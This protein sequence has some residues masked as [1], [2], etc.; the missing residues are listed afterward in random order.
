MI[1]V[2]VISNV[3]APGQTTEHEVE[4]LLPWL[5]EQ[6]A[7]HWPENARIYHR[8]GQLEWDITPQTP[9]DVRH[10]A[11]YEGEVVIRHY[12]AGPDI[13]GV[14]LAIWAYGAISD[15]LTPD[16]PNIKPPAVKQRGLSGGSPNNELGRRTNAARPEERIPDI[17]GQVK[18]IPDLLMVPYT[19]YVDHAEVET[20]YYC[21]TRGQ[22][23]VESIRDGDTL[24]SQ[25]Q[26]ASADVYWPGRAPTGGVAL[27]EPEL[28]IGEPITDDVYNVYQVDAVNGQQMFPTG[29]YT[30]FGSAFHPDSVF[31][32]VGLWQYNGGDSGTIALPF[33]SDSEEITDRLNVGD[34]L[35]VY[36]PM[37]FIPAGSGTAPNL[38]TP[39]VTSAP[40][41]VQSLTVTGI[42][43]GTTRVNVG[44]QIPAAQ[45][46]E[47]ALIPTYFAGGGGLGLF[48]H[49][50]VTSLE[51][52]YVG[53]FFIDF[54]HAPGSSNF[55]V[56]CNFVAPQGL[57][58][59][60][61]TTRHGLDIRMQ[62]LLTPCDSLGNP[63]GTTEAFAG[64]I[65]GSAVTGGIR[66]LTLRCRPTGFGSTTRCLVRA[67]RL[68]NSPRRERQADNV[69]TD[70]YGWN[71]NPESTRYFSGR[72]VD[73]VRWTHCYSMSTPPN[74]SFGDVT[75]IHT[76][77]VATAGALRLKNRELNCVATRMIRTWN[78]TSFA[79][80]LL[81]DGQ[82]QNVLFH[83]M[84]DPFIG[85]LPD[86][87][88]DFAGIVAAFEAVRASVY[89]SF[90]P[91]PTTFAYTL[92][93][94]DLSLEETIQAICQSAFCI[95]Y[96][97]GQIIKVRPEIAGDD[98]A[99][100]LNHRNVLKDT[101]KIAHSFG[102]STEHDS[103]ECGFTDPFDD[104]ITKV[105]V[106]LVGT[107]RS[108]KQVSVIGLRNERQ[109]LWH[110]YRAYFKMLYQRQ[111]VTLEATQEAGTLGVRERVLIADLTKP[112][113][114]TRDGEIRDA[115]GTT[116]RTSQP[117]ALEP[118]RAYTIYLQ[119]PDG[120]V[121]SIP[122]ASS[123]GDFLLTL[124]SVPSPA[125]ITDPRAGV[126][127]KYVLVADDEVSPRAYLVSSVQPTTPMT[128]AVTAANY[129]H[130]HYFADGL[131]AWVDFANG[132]RDLSPV[133]RSFVNTDGVV[134]GGVWTGSFDAS[135]GVAAGDGTTESYTKVLWITATTTP[136]ESGLIQSGGAFVSGNTS[137]MFSISTGDQLVA[138]HNGS[139][140][141]SVDYS[142]Y[143]DTEHMVA[144]TYD[145]DTGRM[146]MFIDGV[147]VDE[148]PAS[149]ANGGVNFYLPGFEGT[150]RVVA[151]WGR[152]CSD[153]EIME[154]YLR[155]RQ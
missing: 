44:V 97:E 60:D 39:I 70:L 80:P 122:V 101:M 84:K 27:H 134:S 7:P 138:G 69:E 124:A 83:V 5:T 3:L 65:E 67:R 47:W 66:A 64:T 2:T 139:F 130:M 117:T 63:T 107:A 89:D 114:I 22:A 121:Q 135:F 62:V 155:G 43:V 38:E 33:A 10:L 46:D 30:F 36:W 119:S 94:A 78:G 144:L 88:I 21:V 110:A 86:S 51:H 79:A 74:I 16:V 18:S 112:T 45:Q 9:D 53:P 141:L 154:F 96:R 152:A 113:A 19:T 145:E 68:T 1:K 140:V 102:P 56:M 8:V 150:C 13:F 48:P 77:T 91:R 57:Y 123:S 137:E 148:G 100:V 108:P 42:S 73:E 109:A 76:R 54:E 32:R 136:T 98:S 12:P 71:G 59:D 147:L 129:S 81:E 95:A 6:Y 26:G 34:Q 120:T 127:T 40:L 115:S 93:D 116:V 58:Q 23:Y 99:L 126:P 25:I 146:A 35:Y 41:T 55:E 105:T 92:D 29:A 149:P 14:G 72:V 118:S 103:V 131:Q 153:R 106:P 37:Q 24:I 61:G 87:R 15:F 125:P 31:V 52:V 28:T 49:A 90:G 142:D 104:T 143:I 111:T 20:A 85:N 75:T 11:T 132:L 17:L 50:Q 4:R 151:K 128:H 133:Q 82:T